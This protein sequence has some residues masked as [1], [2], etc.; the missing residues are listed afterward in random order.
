[1]VV[2]PT[3]PPWGAKWP[4]A[5]CTFSA[6]N[7]SIGGA[8]EGAARVRVTIKNTC[9]VQFAWDDIWIEVRATPLVGQ[10]TV[11]REIA[12]LYG[13]V[14]PFGETVAMVIVYGPSSGPFY[15]YEASL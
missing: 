10:G 9:N 2:G 12:R 8:L 1:L 7:E 13:G 3:N 15:R 14:K 5:R 4:D 11:A 6:E